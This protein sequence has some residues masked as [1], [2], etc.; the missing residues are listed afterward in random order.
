M[1]T[2]E[3]QIIKNEMITEVKRILEIRLKNQDPEFIDW[4]AEIQ[5]NNVGNYLLGH[6]IGDMNVTLDLLKKV[7]SCTSFSQIIKHL[8]V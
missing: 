4:Y 3:Q 7:P 1:I 5:T 6:G 2:Q 8:K